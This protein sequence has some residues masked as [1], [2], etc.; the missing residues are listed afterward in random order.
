MDSSPITLS[1]TPQSQ[2]QDYVRSIPMPPGFDP[3]IY[4]G[5]NDNDDDNEETK[6]GTNIQQP[7]LQLT[8]KEKQEWLYRIY[9]EKRIPEDLYNEGK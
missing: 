2:S 7:K 4:F 3:N 6:N 5:S 1:S 9:D 8:W